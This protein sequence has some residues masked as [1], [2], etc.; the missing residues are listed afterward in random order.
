[1]LLVERILLPS[2][3][4]RKKVLELGSLCVFDLCVVLRSE[5][6]LVTISLLKLT[7]E[8]SSEDVNIRMNGEY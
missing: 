6:H 5:S 4:L 8:M 7:L 1:M 3:F 2:L